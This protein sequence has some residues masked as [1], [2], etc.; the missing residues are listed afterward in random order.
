MIIKVIL[1]ISAILVLMFLLTLMEV[2]LI[3]AINKSMN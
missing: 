1:C 3:A 2:L